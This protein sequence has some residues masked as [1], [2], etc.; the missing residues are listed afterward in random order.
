MRFR[1]FCSLCLLVLLCTC[2]RP[3]TA[4]DWEAFLPAHRPSAARPAA[5]TDPEAPRQL[6]V[7]QSGPAGEPLVFFQDRGGWMLLDAQARQVLYARP[8]ASE[9]DPHPTRVAPAFFSVTRRTV[10]VLYQQGL[11]A[12]RMGQPAL[13]TAALLGEPARCAFAPPFEQ[14]VLDEV[15]FGE[16][17]DRKLICAVLR[18]APTPDT[19]RSCTI[20]VDPDAGTV[21]SACTKDDGN[22][23]GQPVE[24]APCAIQ[25]PL[26]HPPAASGW[27]PDEA[28]CGLREESS[29]RTLPLMP[30]ADEPNPCQIRYEGQ[31]ADG[32]FA[33]WCTSDPEPDYAGQKCR[34]V[35]QRR[36]RPLDPSVNLP[37]ET[38]VRWDS[39]AKAVLVG[40]F[41]FLLHDSPVKYVELNATAIFVR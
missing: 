10:F 23:T 24:A 16:D 39:S 18:D 33:I 32:R 21:K 26:M 12:I 8:P 30:D 35:D 11:F 5:T 38:H 29:G 14:H 1:W 28:V 25:S 20:A 17:P 7:Q 4:E 36:A 31:S 41:L 6:T 27:T 9:D 15:D 34:V 22:Q 37:V 2:R 40:D 3:E 19:H 13:V